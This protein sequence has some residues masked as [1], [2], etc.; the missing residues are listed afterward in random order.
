MSYPQPGRVFSRHAP[1]QARRLRALREFIGGLP[2]DHDG[3]AAEL[4][5]ELERLQ[6]QRVFSFEGGNQ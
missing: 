1:K 6:P 4:A 3:R 5:A 2:A